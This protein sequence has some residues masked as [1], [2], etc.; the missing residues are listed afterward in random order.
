M[1]YNCFAASLLL[2]GA[3]AI[4]LDQHGI[5][6]DALMQNNPSH[7][8]KVWPEGVIDNA[9]GDAD[10]LDMFNHPEPGPPPK[11]KETYPWSY[12][13]DVVSTKASVGTAESRLGKKLSKEGVAE[14]GLNMIFH[15]DN[16]KRVFERDL[17][18][19]HTWAE[20]GHATTKPR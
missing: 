5:D 11:A 7:W 16:T 12:D 9:E 6:G 1:K 8:R 20:W 15:Y 14:R 17:P 19:G 4:H 18:Y 13:D 10:V 3:A 2:A